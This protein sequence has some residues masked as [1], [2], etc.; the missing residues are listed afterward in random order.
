MDMRR[1]SGEPSEVLGGQPFGAVW[2]RSL[3]V[4]FLALALGAA[5]RSQEPPHPAESIAGAARN[6]R[7][8]KSNS[9]KHPK[10]TTNDNLSEQNS[11]LSASASPLESS[12]ASAAEIP[13]PKRAECDDPD[14]ERLKT[15]LLVAQD[16]QDQIRRE[17]S[18]QPE[19]I[20]G[21]NLDLNNF[22]L[23]YSGIHVGGPPLL[24]TQPPISA[25]LKEVDLEE[26]IAS[27]KRALRIACDAPEVAETQTRLD[28]AEQ[29]LDL[30]QRQLVLDQDTYYSKP[31]YAGDTASK[32]RL[33]AKLKQTQNLKSEIER[34]KGEL[35]A[36][37]ANQF[38]K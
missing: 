28:S 10:I 5:L 24:E 4:T 14:A 35:A 9:T 1:N 15:D 29:E 36:S 11:V 18:Y 2:A 30:L 12:S 3:T 16:E 34:L 6:A 19:V 33:D 37:K 32:A 38:S 22:K 23:G 31:N 25:R 17:L 20:S 8:H 13:Q 21:P 27:V 26:K 7:E